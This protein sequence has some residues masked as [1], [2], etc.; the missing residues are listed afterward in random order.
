M[1]KTQPN[2]WILTNDDLPDT[3][4]TVAVIHAIGSGIPR[5][6]RI[7]HRL[8][9][10]GDN[11]EDYWRLHGD[12]KGQVVPQSHVLAWYPLPPIPKTI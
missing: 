6:I 9:D 11:Y 1:S 5:M 7:G 10:F 12:P 2:E 4:Q 8:E 3:N